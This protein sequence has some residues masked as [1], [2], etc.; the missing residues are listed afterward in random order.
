MSSFD[1]IHKT[2]GSAD[3]IPPVNLILS[4]DTLWSDFSLILVLFLPQNKITRIRMQ[5]RWDRQNLIPLRSVAQSV[6]PNIRTQQHE[7][8]IEVCQPHQI[9]RDQLPFNHYRNIHKLNPTQMGLPVL[10][11]IGN[12]KKKFMNSV[13]TERVAIATFKI[14]LIKQRRININRKDSDSG[15]LFACINGLEIQIHRRWI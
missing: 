6:Q 7:L 13:H 3:N 2:W 1:A 4:Y 10:T 12:N 5:K 14:V 8:D 9:K 15:S 11:Q